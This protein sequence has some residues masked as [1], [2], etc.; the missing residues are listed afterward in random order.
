MAEGEIKW[1]NPGNGM[2]HFSLCYWNGFDYLLFK[3]A[4]KIGFDHVAFNVSLS[5]RSPKCPTILT[6]AFLSASFGLPF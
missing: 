2:L 3:H 1:T 4:N 6:V 5:A